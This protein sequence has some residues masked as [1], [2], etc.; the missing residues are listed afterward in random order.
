MHWLSVSCQL[1]QVAIWITLYWRLKKSTYATKL[2]VI[3]L[4]PTL[5]KCL[6]WLINA[7][8][9]KIIFSDQLWHIKNLGTFSA[10]CLPCSKYMQYI[11]IFFSYNWVETFRERWVQGCKS[12]RRSF[13]CFSS[14]INHLSSFLLNCEFE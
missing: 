8:N 1:P 6:E 14:V 10:L 7:F 12:K 4:K 11:F 9:E 13:S 2:F 5:S 3:I